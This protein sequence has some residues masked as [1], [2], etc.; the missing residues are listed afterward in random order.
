MRGLSLPLQVE[1]RGILLLAGLTQVLIG[2]TQLGQLPIEPR[3]LLVP[4]LDGRL[5]LLKRGALSLELSLHFLPGQV[6]ALEGGLCL[7]EGGLLLLEPSLRLL[8]RTLL[9][10]ELLPHRGK[11]GDLVRQV[12]P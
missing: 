3:D 11:R 8:A 7:L 9:L 6:R 1:D 4:E 12:C 2:H 5:C 10:V